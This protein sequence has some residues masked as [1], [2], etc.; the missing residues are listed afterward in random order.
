MKRIVIFLIMV[1]SF[2]PLSAQKKKPQTQKNDRTTTTINKNKR[3]PKATT[4]KKG[5]QN[6]TKE[7]TKPLKKQQSATYTNKSIKG[8]QNERNKIQK[9][10]RKQEQALNENKADVKKRLD[11]LVMING[12]IVE[13]QNNI[14]G[15]ETDIHH[16]SGNIDIL[17]SQL[18]TLEQQLNERKTKYIQSM[19][20]LQRHNKMQ[21]KL[22]FIFS[23]KNF[24]QMFRRFRFVKEYADYQRAQGEALKTK[25][26]QVKDKHTQLQDV[27]QHKSN[28]LWKGQQEKYA[29]QGQQEEQKKI[30]VA[31]NSTQ[32]TIQSI[33]AEQKKKDAALNA[34]IDQ[35]VE[36]EVYKARI[37]AAA[38]AKRKAQASEEAKHRAEELAQRKAAAEAAAKENARR[39]AEARAR[40]LKAQ[41][42][43]RAAA[44]AQ[45]K[46]D[47]QKR[48]AEE[49]AEKKR[50]ADAQAAA[51]VRKAQ[52]D[53]AER[54]A[55]AAVEAAERKA[56]VEAERN[57]KA[58]Q[59]AKRESET[60][61]NLSTVDLML[62]SNFAA[63]KGRLPMP[64][65]GRYKIVSHYGQYNVEGLKNVTLDNKGIN[66]KGNPGCMA[67]SIFNG[68][69]SA[70]FGLGGSM[71]VM[72]RHGEYI[73][74]YCNLR[75]VNVSTGQKVSTGQAL[76]SVGSNNILQFQLRKETAKLNPE[77]WLGR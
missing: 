73:S 21:D 43:A 66:I 33:I 40:E 35:L 31:L 15:I 53:Q 27:R 44:E 11:D 23:A 4:S 39:I 16:I 25:Q 8:L 51:D 9:N 56:K 65:T 72:V 37:R 20:Y 63:N 1:I 2:L 22:M 68:E 70:V 24:A 18:I 7:A 71:V 10:I 46:A 38:E 64:I 49:A 75:S 55:Q 42:E 17:K 32:K 14:K 28:L 45:R 3:D 52:A 12:Q 41:E 48:V 69:I 5:K 6:T 62:S 26:E 59:N 57:K 54:E 29:L 76:G 77:A 30:V 13:R 58:I 67:R 34:R 74:V 19:H 47:A 50:A 60:A 61:S 36:R